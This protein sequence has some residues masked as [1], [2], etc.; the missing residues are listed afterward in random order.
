VAEAAAVAALVAASTNAERLAAAQRA[1]L[2][3]KSSNR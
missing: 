3:L 1:L 2:G